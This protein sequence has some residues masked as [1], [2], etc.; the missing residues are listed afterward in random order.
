MRA[1]LP[2]PWGAPRHQACR[3]GVEAALGR[4]GQER[5]GAQSGEPGVAWAPPPSLL[6]AAASIAGASL[7]LVL[8]SMAAAREGGAQARGGRE[9]ARAHALG[10]WAVSQRGRARTP[11]A[12]GV[13][14]E[15]R[16]EAGPA[17]CS[18]SCS[19]FFSC[20]PRRARW[21]D[22]RGVREDTHT[23]THTYT[24][25]PHTHHVLPWTPAPLPHHP[26]P[27]RAVRGDGAG[28]LV[29]AGRGGDVLAPARAGR[30]C[31]G[32]RAR[33]RVGPPGGVRA[34]SRACCL[35]GWER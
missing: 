25:T 2:G 1:R 18:L 20:S 31:A 11:L 30:R 10:G 17:C 29:P 12:R 6:S 9:C 22:E 33:A 27:R 19:F 5:R 26:H 4:R 21:R 35:L 15:G 24:H 28:L 3:A 13:R 32:A 7:T 8:R 14:E 23:H 16:S 34:G